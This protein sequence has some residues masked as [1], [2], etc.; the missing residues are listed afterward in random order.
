[1][2]TTSLFSRS[3]WK[4]RLLKGGFLF[5]GKGSYTSKTSLAKLRI[6]QIHPWKLTWNLKITC[7]KRKIIF[8]TFSFRFHVN[9]RGCSC[10]GRDEAGNNWAFGRKWVKWIS[11]CLTDEE[12]PIILWMKFLGLL[13]IIGLILG[14]PGTIVCWLAS[15]G[16]TI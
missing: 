13:W 2:K 3:E 7:L 6:L 4:G 9:F 15:L 10:L 11:M 8:Q 14:F 5:F 16:H 12:S 1:M